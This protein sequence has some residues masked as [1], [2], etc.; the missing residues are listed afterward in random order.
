MGVREG[1][2]ALLSRG[3]AHGYQLKTDLEQATGNTWSLNIGQ[4]YT[5]LSRHERDG[6]VEVVAEDDDRKVY[7]LTAAGREAAA[8]WFDVPVERTIETRDEV[9]M[10]VLVGIEAG[11]DVLPV[12][13]AQRDA[14]MAAVARWTQQK[15]EAFTAG[16][17]SGPPSEADRLARLVHLDRLI[18]TARAEVEWLDLVEERL[19]QHHS[20]SGTTP[21]PAGTTP[22]TRRRGGRRRGTA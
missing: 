11:V 12:I 14:T 13:G 22:T 7:D 17:G 4:V 2:L 9:A 1:L 20:R 18:L 21:A 10:K 16:N 15:N 3:P 5:T 8:D 6:L 19:H